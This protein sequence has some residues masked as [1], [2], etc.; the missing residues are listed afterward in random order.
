MTFQLFNWFEKAK[1]RL[2]LN[3]ILGKKSIKTIF[4]IF[5]KHKN[6]RR[7]LIIKTKKHKLSIATNPKLDFDA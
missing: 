3:I 7:Q 5:F 1:V 6:K 2:F 4:I